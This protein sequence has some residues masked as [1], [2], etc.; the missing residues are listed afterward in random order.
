[1]EPHGISTLLSRILPRYIPQ[2]GDC[3]LGRIAD[4]HSE[5]YGVDINT[6][7]PASLP[8]LAFEGATRR[9]RPNLQV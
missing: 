8:V 1:M 7:F 6:P 9:S 5:N 3:V 4:K 2:V